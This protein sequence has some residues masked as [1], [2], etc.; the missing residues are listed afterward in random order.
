MCVA[1]M[2]SDAGG[3]FAWATK[4]GGKREQDRLLGVQSSNFRFFLSQSV[5]GQPCVKFRNGI[6]Y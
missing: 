1:R 2:L 4:I 3:Y 5:T 6:G